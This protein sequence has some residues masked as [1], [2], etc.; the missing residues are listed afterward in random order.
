[1]ESGAQI[2]NAVVVIIAQ[3]HTQFQ[4]ED[5]SKLATLSFG[6]DALHT[7]NRRL[8][9][10]TSAALRSCGPVDLPMA[11]PHRACP[12]LVSSDLWNDVI[13]EHRLSAVDDGFFGD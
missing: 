7:R 8:R 2:K 12:A 5:L 11:V 3:K 10:T 13:S 9:A 6:F 1:M 4:E